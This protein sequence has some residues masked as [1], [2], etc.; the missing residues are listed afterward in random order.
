M[1]AKDGRESPPTAR[2]KVTDPVSIEPVR[3]FSS[4]VGS[5]SASHNT[6]LTGETAKSKPDR[7]RWIENLAV[8]IG[9]VHLLVAR[10]HRA[11]GHLAQP[12]PLGEPAA[13]FQGRVAAWLEMRGPGASRCVKPQS[14]RFLR[15]VTQH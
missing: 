15:D 2:K 9:R 7:P 10:A 14:I 5:A 4:N 6:R 8:C 1:Q 12:P 13:I 11:V 3:A